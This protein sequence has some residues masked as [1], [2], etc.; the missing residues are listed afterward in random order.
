MNISQVSENIANSISVE[1]GYSEEKKEIISYGIESFILSIIGLILIV[2]VSLPLKVFYPTVIAVIF[3]GGL[4]K[5][6][7]GA[8]FNTPIKCLTLGAVIYPLL[9]LGAKQIIKY[10]LH[11]TSA[12]L[13]IM[14]VSLIVIIMFAPVDSESKPIHSLFFKKKLKAASITIV[15]FTC[16]VIL[17]NINILFSTAAVLGVGYQTITLLPVFNKSKKEVFL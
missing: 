17:L 16:I 5:V 10:D 14:I 1:L 9:G 6:S 2:I 3:G 4:R 8:H 11:S 15:I 13:F 12:Y 7:G